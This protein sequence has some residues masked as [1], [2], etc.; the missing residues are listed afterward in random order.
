MFHLA[1]VVSGPCVDHSWTRPRNRLVNSPPLLPFVCVGE[2]FPLALEADAWEGE[3]R[4]AAPVSLRFVLLKIS[5]PKRDVGKGS[6]GSREPAVSLNKQR[7]AFGQV[8]QSVGA[9]CVPSRA[10]LPGLLR[11]CDSMPETTVRCVIQR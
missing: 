7:T 5:S 2:L 10:A 3:E 8:A 1:A 11:I 9:G 6:P 4:W